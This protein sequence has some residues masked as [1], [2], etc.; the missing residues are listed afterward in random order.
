MFPFAPSFGRPLL[1]A[2]ALLAAGPAFAQLAANS[3]FI[4]AGGGTAAPT[5]NA[6]LEYRGMMTTLE[7]QVQ[8]RIYDPARKAGIWLKLNEHNA[9][10]GVVAKQ[11]DSEHN[12][13]A[14]EHQGQTLTLA[15]RVA[16][17]I[18]SGAAPQIAA[19]PPPPNN[20]M[21]PSVT[22]SVAVNP[23]PAQEQ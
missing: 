18:N 17:T 5:Q 20:P 10:F 15:E 22:Q 12:T 16:K 9:D 2:L 11:Y 7:G 13:L 3:P 19:A 4:S 14:V 23:T 1:V 6:P 21:L 8:Y